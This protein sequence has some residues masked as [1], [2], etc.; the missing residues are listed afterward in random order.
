MNKKL[1][2]L[3]V[4][5]LAAVIALG[6]YF[7]SEYGLFG[8][9][10]YTYNIEYSTNIKVTLDTTDGFRFA[11][12]NPFTVSEHG[13][14]CTTGQ[15]IYEETYDQLVADAT[16]GIFSN[17]LETGSKDGFEYVF[18]NFADSEYNIVMRFGDTGA[19]IALNNLVSEESARE[20]FDRLTFAIVE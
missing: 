4:V 8:E 16:E 2:C 1:I 11:D 19:A 5:V 14:A 20:C 7:A 9:I 12:G 3:I 13:E 10:S 15:F 18:W 6:L 17:I